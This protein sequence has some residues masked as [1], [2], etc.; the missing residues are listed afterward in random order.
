MKRFLISI[1]VFLVFGLAFLRAAEP[2]PNPAEEGRCVLRNIASAEEAFLSKHQHYATLK[3]LA[4]QQYLT[5]NFQNEAPRIGHYTFL[6]VAGPASFKAVA[7][8]DS[9][10]LP[11]LYVDQKL[12]V[13][14]CK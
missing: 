3:E 2:Q 7:M 8:P 13:T 1:A 10:D 9:V 14:D 11:V 4:E 5:S 6:L 12:E